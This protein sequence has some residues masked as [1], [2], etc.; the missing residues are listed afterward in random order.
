MNALAESGKNVERVMQFDTVKNIL[1]KPIDMRTNI[2]CKTLA[3]QI[4]EIE[5]FKERTKEGQKLSLRNR[6]I[7]QI[8]SGL[9]Y[10][11]LPKNATV[12]RYG[13]EGD[14]FYLILKGKV[15]VWIPMKHA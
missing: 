14:K 11:E 3:S 5:F 13:E 8:S 4:R 7:E 1:L 6:D 2:E 15:S 10:L 9:E 12:M